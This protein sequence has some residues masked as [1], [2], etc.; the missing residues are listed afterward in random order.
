MLYRFNYK[1]YI[2]KDLISYYK[3]I[4]IFKKISDLFII[5]YFNQFINYY[6]IYCKI[7]NNNDL[8]KIKSISN[9]ILKCNK[10]L[11][12]ILYIY[13]KKYNKTTEYVFIDNILINLNTINILNKL[14]L[15]NYLNLFN[16]DLKLNNLINLFI[17]HNTENLLQITHKNSKYLLF[18]KNYIYYYKPSKIYLINNKFDYNIFIYLYILKQAYFK[19]KYIIIYDYKNII[20]QEFI[21]NMYN[22]KI[23][24]NN[25]INILILSYNLNQHKFIINH[26]FNK[27][28]YK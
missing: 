2:S 21:E 1:I 10:L 3:L 5:I 24:N 23:K 14:E 20:N 25:K 12:K 8:K 9:Y 19:Y 11:N 18:L 6:L 26:K 16:I 13:F 7:N 22:F 15:H 28:F 4:K 17:K 27:L